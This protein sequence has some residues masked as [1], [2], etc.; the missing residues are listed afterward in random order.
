M[1]FAKKQN[2]AAMKSIAM[3]ATVRI[4]S[5]QSIHFGPF[6]TRKAF[7]IERRIPNLLRLGYF[8]DAA[9]QNPEH[10]SQMIDSAEITITD[11]NIYEPSCFASPASKHYRFIPAS[12]HARNLP[13]LRALLLSDS[14]SGWDYFISQEERTK[15]KKKANKAEEPTPNP[16]S[17]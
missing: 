4:G 16:P 3:K 14:G 5:D 10:V 12:R 11:C 9:I 2:V 13:A 8:R 7:I 6:F 17:D 15:L 1:T